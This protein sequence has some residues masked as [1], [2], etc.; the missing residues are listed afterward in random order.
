MNCA[1]IRFENSLDHGR[2]TT[3]TDT[4]TVAL[5]LVLLIGSIALYL[6]TRIQQSE[7]KLGLLE[8]ILLDLKMSSEVNSYTELPAHAAHSAHEA[9]LTEVY[10]PYT[11]TEET[12]IEVEPYKSVELNDTDVTDLT[13]TNVQIQYESLTLKELQTLAKSRGI[14]G[15]TKKGQL[16]EALKSGNLNVEET[17]KE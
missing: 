12:K 2:M 1:R 8:S 9:D 13:D 5:V 16:I 6:Y 11:D 10:V 7:Q 15:I 4:L 3:L 14:T 17:S